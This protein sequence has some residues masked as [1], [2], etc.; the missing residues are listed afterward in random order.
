MSK[1]WRVLQ[2][3]AI[4][5]VESYKGLMCSICHIRHVI[6]DRVK[7]CKQCHSDYNKENRSKHENKHRRSHCINT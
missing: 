5:R 3:R 4:Q 2:P 1:Q 6:Y 7:H